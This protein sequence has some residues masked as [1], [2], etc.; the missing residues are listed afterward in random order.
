MSPKT[1]FKKQVSFKK[2][3]DQK[4]EELSKP[5]ATKRRERQ[6][7]MPPPP[8]PT[9]EF[10]AL[11]VALKALGFSYYRRIGRQVYFVK[12]DLRV[13]WTEGNVGVNIYRIRTA[14]RARRSF[15]TMNNLGPGIREAT[16][17]LYQPP[18]EI[19]YSNETRKWWSMK[20]GKLPSSFDPA[21]TSKIGRK[22]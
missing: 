15:I 19:K 20:Y 10:K 3:N 7:V 1:S 14:L 13:V 11:Q 2:W 21:P 12:D 9:V 18:I 16:R 5:P 4:R 17:D 6:A 22:R 8:I